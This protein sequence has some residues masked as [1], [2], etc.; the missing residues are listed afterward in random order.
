MRSPYRLTESVFGS[1]GGLDAPLGRSG[2]V[3]AGSGARPLGRLFRVSPGRHYSYFFALQQTG[4]TRSEPGLPAPG[5]ATP[6][7]A[8][9]PRG[10]PQIGRASWRET[11]ARTVG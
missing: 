1:L 6:I 5:A 2:S 10:R 8:A 3:L 7:P 11:V 9:A 4:S